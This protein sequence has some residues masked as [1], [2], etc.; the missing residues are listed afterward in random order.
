MYSRTGIAEGRVAGG[1]AGYFEAISLEW[2]ID[3]IYLA[4]SKF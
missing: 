3:A 1:G 2:H 4:L